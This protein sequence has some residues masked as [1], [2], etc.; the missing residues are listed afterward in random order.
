M[1]TKLQKLLAACE[2]E[3]ASLT[4]EM[5]ECVAEMDCGKAH[6]FFKGLVRINQQLQTLNN[7]Q[8]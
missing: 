1:R 5:E 2:A 4:A 3:R 8:D 7:L 6:L